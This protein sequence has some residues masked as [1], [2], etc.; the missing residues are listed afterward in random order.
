MRY[1]EISFN[2]KTYVRAHKA[3]AQR[4][5]N[6]GKKVGICANNM[7]RD[8]DYMVFFSNEDVTSFDAYVNEYS[9]Y[10]CTYK[11]GYPAFFIPYDFGL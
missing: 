1:E 7:R 2:G 3:R 10:N 11:T 8:S 4:C 5:F 6:T 9:Y